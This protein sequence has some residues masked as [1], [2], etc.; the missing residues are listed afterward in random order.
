[1]LLHKYKYNNNIYIM[2]FKC[3]IKVTAFKILFWNHACLDIIHVF[4]LFIVHAHNG[5][6][7]C[8][9]LMKY[10]FLKDKTAT[11]KQIQAE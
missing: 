6:K 8:I 5:K 2:Q 11:K 4:V 1:M 10:Y 3:K 7:Q 9:V